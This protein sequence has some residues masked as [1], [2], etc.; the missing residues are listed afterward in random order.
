M[1]VIQGAENYKMWK[2]WQTFITLFMTVRS[3]RL[4]SPLDHYDFLGEGGEDAAGAQ[5]LL[6]FISL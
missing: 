1:S 2:V 4:H 5:E 6:V 3:N